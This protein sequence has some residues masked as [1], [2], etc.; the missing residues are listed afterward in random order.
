MRPTEHTEYTEEFEQEGTERTEDGRLTEDWPQKSAK[1]AKSGGR[2]TE[3]D[4]VTETTERGH[5][6]G[7]RSAEG[8]TER[9]P[10]S[11]RPRYASC[12]TDRKSVFHRRRA[13]PNRSGVH[14]TIAEHTE[15][16]LQEGPERREGGS[17]TVG[18]SVGYGLLAVRL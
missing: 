11:D 6:G 14:G 17:R 9:I 3:S 10:T 16:F 5:R 4:F 2:R 12:A 8:V 15:G 13:V 1:G 18:V 7:R